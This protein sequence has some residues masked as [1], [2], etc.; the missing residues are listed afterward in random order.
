MNPIVTCL[1]VLIAITAYFAIGIVLA[2]IIGKEAA[3]NLTT[4]YSEWGE[5]VGSA[6]QFACLWPWVILYH[7]GRMVADLFSYFAGD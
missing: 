2:R 1:I 5:E 4:G 6:S 7:S 3:T